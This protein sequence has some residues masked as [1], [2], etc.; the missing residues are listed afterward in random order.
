MPIRTFLGVMLGWVVVRTGS[1]FPAMLMHATYDIT[2]LAYI[3]YEANRQGAH[4]LLAEA[5]AKATEPINVWVL[6]G[7]AALIVGATMMLLPRRR[8]MAPGG[9][10]IASA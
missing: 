1:I 3:S 8:S 9:F 7:G 10:P 4:K 2:Q 5:T 6:A